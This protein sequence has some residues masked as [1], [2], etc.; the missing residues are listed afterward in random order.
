IPSPVRPDDRHQHCTDQKTKQGSCLFLPEC[1]KR[2]SSAGAQ[3]GKHAEHHPK[4][5]F[6][7]EEACEQNGEPQRQSATDC[8]FPPM[9]KIGG[10][11]V[12]RSNVA[13]FA[14]CCTAAL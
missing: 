12:V 9:Q 14:V 3:D 10:Q 5:M 8:T 6:H 4:R 7:F 1:T 2:R 11:N 13:S